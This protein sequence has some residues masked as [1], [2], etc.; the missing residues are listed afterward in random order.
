MESP[1]ASLNEKQRLCAE[2]ID[3]P[4]LVLAGAGSG[5]TRVVTTRICNLLNR[6]VPSSN[7]LAVTFTN[8]AAKEM[9]SRVKEMSS[10]N[11]FIATFHSLCSRILRE[12]IDILDGYNTSFA[13]YDS[14]DS[15][16]LIKKCFVTLGIEYDK[17]TTRSILGAIS[18][19]KNALI[20][21]DNFPTDEFDS[22]ELIR[23]IYS[24]YQD[25]LKEC[26]ALDFD[27]LLLMTH[28]L[29]VNH[30]EVLK[31]YQNLWKFILIDEYQ[32]T[33]AVQY[34]LIKKLSDISHNVFA[35]GDPDQ[36]IY[37]WRGANIQN[38]LQF[39][40]DFQGARVVKLEQNYRSTPTI[41]KAANSVIA[42]NTSRYEKEL[43]S[44]EKDGDLITMEIAD[45]DRDEAYFVIDS[46]EKNS[47]KTRY[48]ECVIFYRTNSQSRIYEDAL[49]RRNIP[50]T[51]IGGISFYDRKEI[52]DIL[53]L[54]RTL[55]SQYD[56]LAFERV[57]NT[58]K[59][60]MGPK[61]LENI[62]KA[63]HESQLP[64]ITF[65]YQ[66]VDTPSLCKL[67]AKQ[68]AAIVE[69]MEVHKTLSSRLDQS[70]HTTIQEI[71][72]LFRYDEYLKAD[73]ETYEERKSNI[74]ELLSKAYEWEADAK[75]SS[76]VTFLEEISLRSA[77]DVNEAYQDTVKLMTLHNSKGLEFDT[78][79]MVGLEEDLF[80]HINSKHST[81]E[82]EE[83]RRLCYVGM[84]RA[85]KTL[86][87]T[88]CKY[89]L[90]YGQ[91]KTMTPS[92]FLYE[93]PEE[94]IQNS[95]TPSQDSAIYVGA[96]VRHQSFGRGVVKK[97]Y[98]TSL[99]P[100]YDVYF[101]DESVI[102]SLIGKYAKLT[103]ET[104]F[105]E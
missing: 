104:E 68:R 45:S 62:S 41:L 10:H 55:T 88:C 102:K 48:N 36:S 67:Q 43:W 25:K 47:R 53:A 100:T 49:L 75:S 11:V 96:H 14:Q 2:H 8:K 17:Q 83:E 97:V 16:S 20:Y 69:F 66:L 46:I 84:T 29:F 33:N 90:L 72:S 30:P 91:P 86:F 44:N 98:Q 37:S 79:Y 57:I 93:V 26:N 12:S 40:E 105:F 78:V 60:G 85:R 23:N 103:V 24:L 58:P 73:K 82:I 87:M 42:I 19:A 35:V 7:I 74:D 1:L 61:A 31:K 52:K 92:R 28:T 63:A 38:I 50:Y 21:P 3:G 13:I 59:R 34:S 94:F 9:V 6:G 76:L 27:D 80:P 64:F 4:L 32:D 5:K 77:H 95:P 18:K 89:R 15:L 39:E 99:G 54:I 51:I 81:D 70:I 65:L 22:G 56:Q 101:P 71:I